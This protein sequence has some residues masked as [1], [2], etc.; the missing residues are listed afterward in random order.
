MKEDTSGVKNF[1]PTFSAHFLSVLAKSVFPPGY[2]R[3]AASPTKN[4]ASLS[5][6]D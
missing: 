6:D 1:S 5:T 3:P 4:D 2:L